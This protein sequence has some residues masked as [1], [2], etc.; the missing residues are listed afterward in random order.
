MM[1]IATYASVNSSITLVVGGFTGTGGPVVI[2][3]Q[4]I[5]MERKPR[6]RTRVSS[7]PCA[8]SSEGQRSS[9]HL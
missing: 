8:S 5:L 7:F 4:F 3:R 6:I 9:L 1:G 2:N